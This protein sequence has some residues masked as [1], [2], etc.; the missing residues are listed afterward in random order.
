MW[1]KLAV[2]MLGVSGRL[3]MCPVELEPWSR[4]SRKAV[5]LCFV[6]VEWRRHCL[7][8]AEMTNQG[9]SEEQEDRQRL[10]FCCLHA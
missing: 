5:L 1:M 9:Q 7:T 2:V 8:L 4:I 6:I 10:G 3:S